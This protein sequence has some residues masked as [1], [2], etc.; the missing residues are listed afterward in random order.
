MSAIKTESKH[1]FV[2]VSFMDSELSDQA[3]IPEIGAELMAT[4]ES[5]S[6][7]ELLRN[8]E[9]VSFLSSA[10]IGQL[11]L[12]SKKCKSKMIT[13]K[14]CNL[15]PAVRE[16]FTMLKLDQLIEVYQDVEHAHSHTGADRRLWFR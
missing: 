6:F 2:V 12:L 11:V 14:M 8:C 13:L 7:D 15:I 9:G 16:L 10:M 3:R 4:A 5:M 1:G